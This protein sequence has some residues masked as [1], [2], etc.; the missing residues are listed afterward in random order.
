MTVMGVELYLNV[1]GYLCHKNKC[2]LAV[3]EVAYNQNKKCGFMYLLNGSKNLFVLI[4]L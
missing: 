2:G 3:N 4:C 1:C